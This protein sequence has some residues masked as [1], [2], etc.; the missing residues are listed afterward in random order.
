MDGNTL[1]RIDGKY[2]EEIIVIIKAI[3]ITG[4]AIFKRLK[5]IPERPPIK[6]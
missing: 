6:K 1:V 2:R 3:N 4:A 5:L